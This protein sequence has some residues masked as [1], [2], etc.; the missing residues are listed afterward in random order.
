MPIV[1]CGTIDRNT[2][3]SLARGEE[4]SNSSPTTLQFVEILDVINATG[5]SRYDNL[6]YYL[7]IKAPQELDRAGGFRVLTKHSV[8]DLTLPHHP[9]T[10]QPADLQLEIRILAI[11][12]RLG[13]P[14][15][16]HLFSSTRP[17]V[18]VYL[19]FRILEEES[20]KEVNQ[21]RK[22]GSSSTGAWG[23]IVAM[24]K[25]DFLEG[26]LLRKADNSMLGITAKIA[27]FSKILQEN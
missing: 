25:N 19:G 17:R 22:R 26:D 23:G 8:S 11:R 13:G 1:G 4:Y 9:R 7:R 21:W 24:E 20:G 18:D 5:D 14:T 12:E 6:R 3:T 27:I 10:E 15:H 2:T 16:S